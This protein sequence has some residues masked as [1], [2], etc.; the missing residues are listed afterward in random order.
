ML[1]YDYNKALL[2][3]QE[4][5]KIVME[6]KNQAEQDA[7]RKEEE[8]L[9]K[10]RETKIQTFNDTFYCIKCRLQ[11]ALNNEFLSFG[12]DSYKPNEGVVNFSPDIAKDVDRILQSVFISEP[13]LARFT[14][15]QTYKPVSDGDGGVFYDL[16]STSEISLFRFQD[17]IIDKIYNVII[18]YKLC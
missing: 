17:V 12:Y 4:R 15:I 7:K 2:K 16:E 14:R 1:P 11:N 3:C 13:D 18:Q 8:K 9:A 6:E 10:E 5:A